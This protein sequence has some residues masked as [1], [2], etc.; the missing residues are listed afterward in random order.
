MTITIPIS[1]NDYQQFDTSQKV[2]RGWEDLKLEKRIQQFMTPTRTLPNITTLN[3][4]V[5]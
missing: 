3:D 1:G 2:R 5:K 4:R